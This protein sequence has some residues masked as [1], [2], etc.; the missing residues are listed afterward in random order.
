[1]CTFAE[2]QR[3]TRSMEAL[4]HYVWKHKLFPLKEL[5]SQDGQVVEVIDPGLHNRDAGPDFFNSKV[6]I[7]GTLWAGNVEIHDK[8][9]DWFLH[10]HDRDVRYDNVVLHV[11]SVLDAQAVNTKGEALCQVRLE[12]PPNVQAHYTE[13]SQEDLYPPCHRI[14]PS[15]STLMIHSWMSALQ[16]ERLERKMR[17]IRQRVE[18]CDGSWEAAYF[19]TLARNFGF[20]INGDVFEQWAL[21]V[22]LQAVGH[23][24]DNLFQI[25]AMFMG[26]AGLLDINTVPGPY[27][28]EAISEGYFQ[29]MQGEYAY[30][31]RKF[32]LKPINANLW[33]F[34]RLRPQNFPHIRISQLANLYYRRMADLGQ[35]LEATDVESARNVL[36]TQVTPYWETHYTFGSTSVR[37]E[38]NLSVFS[39]NLLIVNTVVPMLFA[40][41]RHKQDDRLCERAFAFLEGLKAE[42]NHIVRMWS[43]C[44][45]LV[46]NAGDSQALIQLKT[47]YCDRKECLR[48]RIGY[49]YL[50]RL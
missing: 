44:G 22:P 11:C 39:L 4:L 43:Q 14:I 32:S 34:L 16:V 19:V 12:V 1:M 36:S 6:K 8:A 18:R 2:S 41:G 9:S 24:R 46:K 17:D 15:L 27:R 45:L 21:H 38:K 42:N 29:K 33:R 37:N 30:L 23:H 25:E 20:G 3:K 49:E 13:L 47:A 48:C 26:Q 10:G 5:L 50:K 7:G 35:L 31:A 40:Y 28:A